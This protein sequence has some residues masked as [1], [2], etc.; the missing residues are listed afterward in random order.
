MTTTITFGTD[1]MNDMD[2]AAYWGAEQL[3]QMAAGDASIS[4]DGDVLHMLGVT[5]DVAQQEWFYHEIDL[6]AGDNFYS[7]YCSVRFKTDHA[8]AGLGAYIV[9]VYDD[10]DTQVIDLGYSQ[11]WKVTTTALDHTAK[12]IDKIRIYAREDAAA[13][14]NGTAYVYYDYILFHTG[15]L[16]FPHVNTV[17]VNIQNKIAQLEVPGRDGDI[18]QHLGMKTAEIVVNVSILEGEAWRSVS[19]N[20]EFDYLLNGIYEDTWSYFTNSRPLIRCQV[21]YKGFSFGTNDPDGHMTLNLHFLVYKLG[22]YSLFSNFS[23][24]WGTT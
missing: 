23:W 8:S 15:T 9:L 13:N 22:A 14:A 4:S 20:P 7:A 17:N 24:I 2:S 18:L 3:T 5:D 19:T 21:M 11:S 16:T 10:A 6:A 1:Y 12:A